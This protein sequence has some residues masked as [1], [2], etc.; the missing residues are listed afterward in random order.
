MAS[1]ARDTNLPDPV[2]RIRCAGTTAYAD[3]MENAQGAAERLQRDAA[4]AQGTQGGN[5]A[6][7]TID[8]NPE[9]VQP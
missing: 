5:H 9:E 6:P 4:E 3:T 2:Y 8:R 1:W 7:A